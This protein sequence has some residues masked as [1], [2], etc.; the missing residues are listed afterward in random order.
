MSATK[1]TEWPPSFPT[2]LKDVIALYFA[3]MES[4]DPKAGER[5]ATE[6]FTPSGC[7]YGTRRT[8]HGSDGKFIL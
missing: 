3:L 2:P 1:L 5:L 6:V 8:Y 7:I 4:D